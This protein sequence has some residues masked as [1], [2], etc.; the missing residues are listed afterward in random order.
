MKKVITVFMVFTI[1]ATVM[2]P[3]GVCADK[4]N[5]YMMLDDVK[6][7]KTYVE[8]ITDSSGQADENIRASFKKKL[9]DALIARHSINFV[10]VNDVKDADIAIYGDITERIWLEVDPIDQVQ[11]ISSAALD[12][13]IQ[14]NYTRMQAVFSVERGEKKK[15]LK[16]LRR[17]FKRSD[18]LWERK[19]QATIT[20]GVMPEEESIPMVEDRLVKVFI[21]KC[22]SKK[23]KM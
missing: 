8:D 9:E 17:A 20:K 7:V 19:I 22:F 10:I 14:E 4:K 21:R 16:S 23:A 6:E 5:L 13:A 11:G 2:S 18:V 12:A 3:A 15:V 1:I